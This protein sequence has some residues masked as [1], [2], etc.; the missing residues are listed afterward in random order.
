MS[1]GSGDEAIEQGWCPY[2]YDGETEHEPAC[3]SC[4]ETLL[5]HGEDGEM[6]VKEEFRGEMN[7]LDDGPE[8]AGEGPLLIGIAV[9]ENE[10]GKLN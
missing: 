2:F 3:P 1:Q 10:P 6:E 4:T 5:R 8:R 7:Y 9:L